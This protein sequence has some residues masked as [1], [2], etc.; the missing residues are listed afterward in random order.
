MG[1]GPRFRRGAL[2]RSLPVRAAQPPQHTYIMRLTASVILLA[3][4]AAAMISSCRPSPQSVLE[5]IEPAARAAA[6]KV[7]SVSLTL[8]PSLASGQV[9]S[10]FISTDAEV[11]A[12][13][14]PVVIL[15]SFDSSCL[16]W[17]RV[18]PL[19][20]ESST[21]AYVLDILGWG[22]TDTANLIKGVGVEAKRAH[23][24]A[25]C[26]QHL[27]GRP[28][29]LVG[30]S[31][32]AATI[33]DFCAYHPELVDSVV[34]CD[35]QALI[36]GTPPV[37]AFAARGGVRLLRSW[38]LRALGQKIAYEDLDRCDT[39]DAIRIGRV[40]CERDR[41]E[42]DSIDWLLGGGYSV[43]SLL[44][45]LRDTRCL[46]LWG[47]QDRVLPPRDNVPTF[48]QTLPDAH[49]R[50]IEECGHVPHLEQ[51]EV[52]ADAIVRFRR[53]ESVGGDADPTK[54]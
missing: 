39:A 23:L 8:P 35:P 33:I 26:E 17:R 6:S 40:H 15:H 1:V 50:W 19:L 43:S 51:P 4:T 42:E 5:F 48:V 47:R 46:L 9:E 34:L 2:S 7:T 38:P 29:M 24:R 28:T 21:E 52:T 22:F 30:S 41:W 14:P 31:L 27:N 25:F 49:F 36:D 20:E 3:S 37:P 16:E 12:S 10:S 53:G 13:L 11:D 45:R 54:M 44:P 18:L 32:G